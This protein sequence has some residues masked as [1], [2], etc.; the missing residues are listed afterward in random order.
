M[1]MGTLLCLCL[2]PPLLMSDDKCRG[3]VLVSFE[4]L[5][6]TGPEALICFSNGSKISWLHGSHL[7][8]YIPSGQGK[9]LLIH[10]SA[11]FSPCEAGHLHRVDRENRP[12]LLASCLFL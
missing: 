1:D 10:S 11:L 7:I 6:K 3:L 5:I 12:R 4:Q 9:I 8:L 2:D